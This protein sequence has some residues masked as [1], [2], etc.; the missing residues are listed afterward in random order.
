MGGG[1]EAVGARMLKVCR[2]S[3]AKGTALERKCACISMRVL[4]L[5]KAR[6]GLSLSWSAFEED[7][8][9][10]REVCRK[11]LL[12]GVKML[13]PLTHRLTHAHTKTH[14]T[15]LCGRTHTHT[16]T[17]THSQARGGLSSLSKTREN[18]GAP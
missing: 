6:G 18:T 2:F 1:E 11:D 12:S 7:A 14:N 10:L 4:I 15:R 16:H 9:W 5:G 3:W 13:Q 8:G 17:H